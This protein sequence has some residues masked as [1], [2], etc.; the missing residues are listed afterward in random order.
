MCHTVDS[1]ATD[2]QGQYNRG[3]YDF[4]AARKRSE[5]LMNIRQ[6]FISH[7]Y[8]EVSTPALSP[9]LIPEPTIKV[10]GTEFRNEF[11]GNLDLYLIPS[12]EIFMK[13]LLA[14]GSGSIFQISQC[15]RNSEQLGDVHNPEF[16]MLEYYTVDADDRDSIAITE[17]MIAATALK[18]IRAGWMDSRPLVI[19][20]HEAMLRYA[21][22][23]MDKAEDISYLR[24]EAR[25]LSLEPGEDESWDDTFNRIFLTYTEPSLPKDRRVY[26]T[27]YPDRI[28]CLAKKADGRPCRKRWEMYIGGI[29]IANCYDEETDR[30]ETRSYFEEEERRLCDERRGTGDVIPPADPSFPQLAIP[31]SSGAAM[32]LDRLLAAHLGLNCIAPL[33]LFPLSD[34]LT[35]GKPK[36]SE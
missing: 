20:M 11:T 32:G 22:V 15:F 8:L 17:D 2:P 4:Q 7:G 16:T 18:G 21:G 12:P 5:L 27:D 3:M 1:I 23:D 25:R 35:S 30:E 10:F 13:K 9:Y 36:E 28:R 19:T 24:S 6:Y 31:Q 26:L 33:L 34:M 14:A 29:E